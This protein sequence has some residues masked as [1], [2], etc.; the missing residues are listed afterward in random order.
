MLAVPRTRPQI[1]ANKSEKGYGDEN[2]SAV[3]SARSCLVER[4]WNRE[5]WSRDCLKQNG[6]LLAAWGCLLTKDYF[7]FLHL[8]FYLIKTKALGRLSRISRWEAY[9]KN[10]YIYLK[11]ITTNKNTGALQLTVLARASC[12]ANFCTCKLNLCKLGNSACH[13]FFINI[14]QKLS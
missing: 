4:V 3:S 12:L 5:V 6:G 14:C 9:V 10:I 1:P 2:G 11:K 13:L 7:W 8:N